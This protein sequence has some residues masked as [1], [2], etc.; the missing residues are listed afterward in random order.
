MSLKDRITRL[1]GEGPQRCDACLQ[2][3]GYAGL[4]HDPEVCDEAERAKGFP[5]LRSLMR[6]GWFAPDAP[7][8]EH[9]PISDATRAL[10]DSGTLVVERD[11]DLAELAER[12]PQLWRCRGERSG[13]QDLEP[14]PECGFMPDVVTIIHTEEAAI[15]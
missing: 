13:P 8:H 9:V 5:R 14:C 15:L 7:K 12:E 10:L 3:D 6:A 11:A 1:E 2:L 4:G